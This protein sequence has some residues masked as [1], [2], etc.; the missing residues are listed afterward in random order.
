MVN[1]TIS[2]VACYFGPKMGVGVVIEYLLNYL[3]PHLNS[4]GYTVNLITNDNVLKNSPQLEK[5]SVNIILPPELNQTFSSKIYFLFKF[6]KTTY[7]KDAK[8]VLYMHDAVI[9]KG[10]KNGIA[11]VHDLNDFEVANKYGVV[12]TAFRKKMVSYMVKRSYRIVAISSFVREQLLI[13]FGAKIENK[14]NIIHNGIVIKNITQQEKIIDNTPY[15]L[16]VGRIDPKGKKLYEILKIFTT[17]QNR[18]SNYR[19]KIVGG[20][21]AFCEKDG[22]EFLDYC[23]TLKNVDYLGF[24]SDEE[25]DLLY[26]NAKATI[27]FSRFEGF[28]FPLLEA[29]LRKCPVI[30]NKANKV[31]YELS[32]GCDI[33]IDERR[34]DDEE[35]ILNKIN[36][37]QSVDKEK[38]YLIAQKYSWEGSADKY[39]S[40]LIK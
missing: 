8:Y 12:R 5:Q 30:T 1:K 4:N 18:Y 40:L 22:Q 32:E 19:L 23:A 34:V 9:G 27:F 16:V 11:I 13:N 14:I 2:I 39:Y 28:G 21:N 33:K 36:E 3:I 38:L 17:Y 10:V 37:L 6:A 25:L 26:L 7:V 20:M 29:F 31:N 24:V 15:F 35:Y